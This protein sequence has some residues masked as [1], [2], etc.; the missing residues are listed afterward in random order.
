MTCT[1]KCRYKT[2]VKALL[3]ALERVRDGAPPLRAY[4]CPECK[5][6]HLTKLV[7]S[8]DDNGVVR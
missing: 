3:V 4:K 8:G 2:R 6:W 5:R 7:S 1:D